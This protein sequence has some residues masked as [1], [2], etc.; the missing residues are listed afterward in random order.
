MLEDIELRKAA[1]LIKA[2]RLAAAKS[3]LSAY[4]K[5]FPESD[6][7]WLLMSYVLDDPRSQQASATRALRLNPENE[8][9]KSRID[10]LLQSQSP[11][12]AEVTTEHDTDDIVQ[13]SLYDSSLS[14]IEVHTSIP[15]SIEEELEFLTHDA[16]S[17]R[18]DSWED[19]PVE[20]FLAYEDVE[21]T[22]VGETDVSRGSKPKSKLIIAGMII[23][24]VAVGFISAKFFPRIFISEEDALETAIAQTATALA[25]MNVGLPLPPTWTPTIIPTFTIGP[26]PSHTLEPTITLTPINTRTPRPSPTPE[27]MDPTL[28]VEFDLLQQQVSD[29]RGLSTSVH[30]NSYMISEAE[31]RSLLEGYYF[32][33][34][35]SEEEIHKTGRVLEALGLIEPDY[36]F[37][38]YVLNSLTSIGGGFYIQETNQIFMIGEQLT[39]IEKMVYVHEY[40]HALVNLNINLVRMNVY[41]QCQGNED[42]CKAIQALIEGDST[43]LMLQWLEQSASPTDYEEIINDRLPS[44]ILPDQDPPP[45][46]LRNAEFLSNEGKLFVETLFSSGDWSGVTQ[47][48]YHLPESTEQILHPAKFFSSERPIAVPSVALETVLG[49]DWEQIKS[50]TLGEWMTYLILG[51]G[52][53]PM[54]QLSEDVA[55]RASDGWGGDQYQVYYNNENSEMILIVHWKWDQPSDTD[56]FSSAMR[57]YLKNRFSGGEF[58]GTNRGCWSGNNQFACLYDGDQENLWIVAPS[59]DLID[60]VEVLYPDFLN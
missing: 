27:I 59:M 11:T 52:T 57:Y 50:N 10:Q 36:D 29:L 37:L 33:Y 45:F 20:S 6:L 5:D 8:Q 35:G 41:P 55:A 3:I 46:A 14:D 47:A 48:Y 39:A 21:R 7:A 22:G 49:D 4:V 15:M 28:R 32:Y 40:N 31:V 25:T 51:Y 54:T 43:L 24:L 23:L 9:A 56:E 34:G 1:A 26:A 42:R 53:N 13:S 12:N 19:F 38:T 18:G 58:L 44:R 30:V 2:G 16:V 17:S 60:G